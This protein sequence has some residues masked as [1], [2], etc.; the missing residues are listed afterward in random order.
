MAGWP[1]PG[2]PGFSVI[3][4]NFAVVVSSCRLL[5]GPT[6]CQGFGPRSLRAPPSRPSASPTTEGLSN[7][8]LPPRRPPTTPQTAPPGPPRLNKSTGVQGP[9]RF[10]A[11]SAGG[12]LPIQ[13]FTYLFSR[14]RIGSSPTDPLDKRATVQHPPRRP[15][16]DPMTLPFDLVRGSSRAVT[17]DPLHTA[18]PVTPRT[19]PRFMTSRSGP[20]PGPS[21]G[22]SSRG[23]S[24][25]GT[26]GATDPGSLR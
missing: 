16:P 3:S 17:P 7:W 12:G 22:S 21:A 13:P 10:P 19:S 11:V 20:P 25:R 1:P 2:P 24:A 15:S 6:G 14:A 5:P 23:C 26:S 8:F 18:G 4:P 9:R